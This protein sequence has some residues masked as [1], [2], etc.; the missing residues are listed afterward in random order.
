MPTYE[1]QCPSCAKQFE[2]FESI[3]S[4]PFADCP[5]CN[6]SVRRS[7]SGGMGII[8]KGSGFYSTDYRDNKADKKSKDS[9]KEKTITK[10][11]NTQTLNSDKSSSKESSNPDKKK[12][13]S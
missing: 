12:K 6:I 11:K 5:Q 4:E 8:F 13:A 7:L 2:K 10:E 3:S 9:K 1:Y